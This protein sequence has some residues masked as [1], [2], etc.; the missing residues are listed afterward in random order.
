MG[1]DCPEWARIV[2]FLQLITSK[3]GGNPIPAALS[4]IYTIG[5]TGEVDCLIPPV[6]VFCG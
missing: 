5:H 4:P 2:V 3:G 1:Y 6:S